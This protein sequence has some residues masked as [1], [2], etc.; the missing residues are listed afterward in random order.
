ML[1]LLDCINGRKATP[2]HCGTTPVAFKRKFSSGA[3][4]L[5]ASN[6]LLY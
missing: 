6:M 5:L 3:Y 4:I 2:L 1:G